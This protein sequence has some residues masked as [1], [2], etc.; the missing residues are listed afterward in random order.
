M[1]PES[2]PPPAGPAVPPP[3]YRVRFRKAGDLR[4]VS[5]HDLM[6]CCERMF[7]RAALPV[8]FTH[9]FNPRPRMWFAQS[10]ALG[11]V[12]GNEVL[13]LEL[14]DPLPATDVLDRLARQCPPGIEIRSVRRLEGRASARVRR[15]FFRLPLADSVA[16]LSDRVA[17]FLQRPDCWLERTRPQRRRINIRPYVSEL[18]AGPDGLDMALW[19]SAN[20]AARPDEVIDALGLGDRLAAGAV[21]ERTDLE[22]Y[23]EL[24]EG[25]PGPPDLP[26]TAAAEEPTEEANDTPDDDRPGATRPTAIVTGPLSFDS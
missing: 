17:R 10:L 12:G 19:I 6:H 15:A 23:D 22:L 8:P 11:I 20:G 13:E 5:H 21:L 3:K 9:G 14:T 24:P 4:L 25:T 18:S 26:P 7:R 2:S 16:D 1:V